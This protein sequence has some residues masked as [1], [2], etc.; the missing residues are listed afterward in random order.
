MNVRLLA[1]GLVLVAAGTSACSDDPDETDTGPPTEAEFCGGFQDFYDALGAFE[2]DEVAAYI[3]RL[4]ESASEVADLGVPEDM[5]AGAE[6][7]LAF[8][9]DSVAELADDAT[10]KDI[11]QL[12][13]LALTEEQQ[14]NADALQAYLEDTCPDLSI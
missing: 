9:L 4:K 11:G 8:Y 6:A 7:G 14:G 13:D 1:A 3:Q 10:L 12:V 2:G 5:P